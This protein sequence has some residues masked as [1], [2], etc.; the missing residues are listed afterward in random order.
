M[1]INPIFDKPIKHQYNKQLYL[2]IVFAS[3]KK[4]NKIHLHILLELGK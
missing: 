2:I 1:P 4:Y 3:K